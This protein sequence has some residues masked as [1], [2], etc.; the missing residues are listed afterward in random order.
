L[1]D[2]LAINVIIPTMNEAESIGQTIDMIPKGE[3]IKVTIVDAASKDGTQKIAKE[4]GAEIIVEERRGYGRAYKT[5]FDACTSDII[6]TFDGDMT[7]P[8]EMTQELADILV[9]DE[10]DFISCDRLS[11]LK[12]EAMTRGHRLGNWALVKTMNVLFSMKLKDSQTGMWVFRR[13]IWPKLEVIS[14]GMPFSEEIKVEAWKKGFRCRE[15]AVDYRPRIGEI[16]LNTW[17]D[18]WRNI[19]YL[20]KKRYGH[21]TPED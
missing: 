15:I 16:K 13:E 20:F 10:L 17:G 7:Y 4:H 11:K 14:D 21:P 19:K 8:A 12:P 3:N 9:K 6:V 18:G 1:A 5:G 2:K